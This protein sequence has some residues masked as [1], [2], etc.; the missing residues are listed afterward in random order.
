MAKKPLLKLFLIILL[1]AA[2]APLSAGAGKA[3][4]AG[5]PRR[6]GPADMREDIDRF[7]SR[8]LY[9]HYGKVKDFDASDIIKVEETAFQ[10]GQGE[11]VV[12]NRKLQALRFLIEAD[13]RLASYHGGIAF[14]LFEYDGEGL[15][16]KVSY[17]D[18]KG[19]LYGEP[20]FD[21]TAVFEFVIED[22]K[23]LKQKMNIIDEREGNIELPE[24]RRPVTLRLLNS[25][26][27]LLDERGIPTTD[28]W[29]W[30]HMLFRP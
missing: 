8:F 18:K 2:L 20:E 21:D 15:L 1:A 23:N 22:Y 12:R 24:R 11:I 7:K 17:Y 6:S 14:C 28:Y 3:D 9:L 10:D 5:A 16:K 19:K 27:D 25:S 13:H 30:C 4:A 29:M 26:G